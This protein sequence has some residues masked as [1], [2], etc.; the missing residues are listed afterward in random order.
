[1]TTTPDGEDASD[2]E[3]RPCMGAAAVLSEIEKATAKLEELEQQL[4]QK[5]SMRDFEGAAALQVEIGKIR[6][7]RPN[8]EDL[9]RQLK[10]ALSRSDYAG[11]AS[12]SAELEKTEP[13]SGF[14][15]ESSW[16]T[17][18]DG[19]GR[20]KVVNAFKDLWSFGQSDPRV[21]SSRECQT[22]ERWE[23]CGGS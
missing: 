23:R 3:D 11:A 18:G 21:R 15:G 12:I 5:V 4:Q 8:A 22:A 19:R 14:R 9:Q 17:P 6:Q 13:S 16:T 1:M 20:V 10:Q 7:S 2:G